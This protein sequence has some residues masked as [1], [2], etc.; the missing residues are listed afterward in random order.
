M[1]MTSNQLN[2][3]KDVLTSCFYNL[4][5]Q[6]EWI[7][8]RREFFVYNLYPVLFDDLRACLCFVDENW[9]EL[10]QFF[11]GLAGEVYDC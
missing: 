5:N 6:G 3:A 1:K 8:S 11:F 4:V 7:A 10:S 2:D 9:Q